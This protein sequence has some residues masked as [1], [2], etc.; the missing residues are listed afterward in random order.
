MRIIVLLSYLIIG[1][2]AL[3]AQTHLSLKDI[4]PDEDY[5]NIHVK[6]ISDDEEQTTFIIWV[7]K[8]V[9]AHYHAV[10]S[11]NIYVLEGKGKMVVDGKE[12]EIKAGDYLNFAKGKVHA[13]LEV[14][15]R[16]PLKVISVQSPQFL[17]KDRIFVDEDK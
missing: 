2:S 12:I 16:K 8:N 13:V 6:K 5:E 10:H 7:K 17:G 11:E 14:T 1:V 15:S 9:K 3:S 4:E